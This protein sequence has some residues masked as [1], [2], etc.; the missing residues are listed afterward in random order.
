MT[1]AVAVESYNRVVVVEG[2]TLL[3]MVELFGQS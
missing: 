3:S 1:L 2:Y